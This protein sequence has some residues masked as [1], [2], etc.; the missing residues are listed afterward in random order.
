MTKRRR[1]FFSDRLPKSSAEKDIF[2]SRFCWILGGVCVLLMIV[3]SGYAEK[4]RARL[5][6]GNPTIQDR[7]RMLE[8]RVFDLEEKIDDC[9]VDGNE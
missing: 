8:Q 4:E 6:Y 9:E 2:W 1:L 7:I 3:I 5:R